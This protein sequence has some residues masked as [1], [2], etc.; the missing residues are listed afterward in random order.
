MSETIDELLVKMGLETD[1]Q[2]FRE[3][4][5]LFSGLRS[6]ALL[7]GAAIGAIGAGMWSFASNFAQENDRL[8]KFSEITGQ[9]AQFVKSLGFALERSGGQAEG[10]FSSIDKMMKL[11]RDIELGNISGLDESLMANIDLQS[12]A[13]AGSLAEAYERMADAVSGLPREMSYLILKELA[14]DEYEQTLLTGGSDNMRYLFARGA[15]LAPVRNEYLQNAAD[16]NDAVTDLE[17]AV[18]GVTDIIGND[19]SKQLAGLSLDF[20][21]LISEN[22]ELLGWVGKKATGFG[23]EWTNLAKG[24][25]YGFFYR[26]IKGL[27]GFYG[28]QLENVPD[29][30]SSDSSSTNAENTAPDSSWLPQNL[31][32]S[33]LIDNSSSNTVNNKQGGSVNL[34]IDR[35]EI[36][37]GSGITVQGV[38]RAVRDALSKIMDYAEAATQGDYQ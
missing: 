29:W 14:F 37:E 34:R 18:K 19:L 10:A 36:G 33:S 15:Y 16:F 8:G 12:V 31:A 25:P 30:F 24:G 32:P 2:S 38:E 26:R 22:R 13:N 3:G 6:K 27:A 5:A 20:A 11:M 21:N 35:I 17:Y 28:E 23:T 9:S 4:E 1:A 7:F